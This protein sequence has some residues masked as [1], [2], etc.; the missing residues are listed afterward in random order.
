MSEPK[1]TEAEREILRSEAAMFVHSRGVYRPSE[2]AD[3][4]AEHALPQILRARLGPVEAER[5]EARRLLALDRCCGHARCPGGSLCCCADDPTEVAA[6]RQRVADLISQRD[7]LGEAEGRWADRTEAAERALAA[8]DEV[9]ARVQALADL[10]D[11]KADENEA[12]R[13]VETHKGD[14]RILKRLA[15]H[16][17][18]F[19]HALRAELAVPAPQSDED[20]GCGPL[21]DW[22]GHTCTPPTTDAEE[23][24]DA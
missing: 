16:Q 18:M 15:R 5:D 7:V 3:H 14:R 12:R 11:C 4:L 21:A 2:L 20:C 10:W 9:I 6:L 23:A 13:K 8:R 24:T 17:R 22:D 1:L 19:A